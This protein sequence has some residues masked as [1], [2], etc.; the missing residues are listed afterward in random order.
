MRLARLLRRSRQTTDI[1][2]TDR[3]MRQSSFG[4]VQQLKI[5]AKDGRQLSWRQVWSAFVA[6]YPG[7]WGVQVFPPEDQLV[8]SK[9]VYHLFVLEGEPEGLNLR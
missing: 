2:I 3:G 8:D 1:Q 5:F 7:R 9:N 4:V 6:E